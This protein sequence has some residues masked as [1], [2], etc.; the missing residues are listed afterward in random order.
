MII[1]DMKITV[2][3][4]FSTIVTIFLEC[5]ATIFNLK[6]KKLTNCMSRYK[7]ILILRIE[8]LRFC[9]CQFNSTC[10]VNQNGQNR[11]ILSTTFNIFRI[12]L[13]FEVISVKTNRIQQYPLTNQIVQ[14]LKNK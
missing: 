13:I 5:Q 8:N 10:S 11:V 6:T 9:F 3:I 2:K 1:Y 7:K 4:F 14:I 12:I